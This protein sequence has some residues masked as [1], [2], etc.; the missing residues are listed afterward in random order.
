MSRDSGIDNF[1]CKPA[2]KVL[3]PYP[4]MGLFMMAG[5]TAA[6][7]CVRPVK[8]ESRPSIESSVPLWLTARYTAAQSSSTDTVQTSRRCSTIEAHPT[9]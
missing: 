9:P 3:Y 6:H 4:T 1:A 7:N 2:Q 5:H 8:V